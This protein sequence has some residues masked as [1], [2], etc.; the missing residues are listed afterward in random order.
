MRQQEGRDTSDANNSLT[1]DDKD[2][3]STDVK[4]RRMGLAVQII[5]GLVLGLIC[6]I[7]FGEKVAWLKIAGGI[8][9]QLLQIPVIPYMSLALIT[10]IGRMSLEQVKANAKMGGGV[11]L[12][13]S[14]LILIVVLLMPLSFPDWPSAS[15]FST[16]QIEEPPAIDYLNLFIPAN[17]FNAYATAAIPAIVLFS[18]L[19]GIAIIS[20]PNKNAL[21]EPLGVLHTAMMKITKIIAKLAPIGVFAL[22]AGFAGTFEV[23]ELMRLQVYIVVYVLLTLMLSIVIIPGIITVFTPL[24]YREILVELR[25]PLITAF[26]TSSSLITLPLL[27]DSC[28]N[29]VIRHKRL[30]VD[31]KTADASID[32]L[33]PTFFTFPNPSTMLAISFILYAGWHLG[34]PISETSYPTLLLA[35]VPSLFGGIFVAVPF[36]LKLSQLPSDL[37]QL[38]ILISVFIARFGVLLSSMHYA[39]IGIIGT[40]AGTGEL[41]FRWLRLIRV[42]ATGSVLTVPILLGV[43]A[44]YTHVVV[45]PYTKNDLLKSLDFSTPP[46]PSQVFTKVPE[47]LVNLYENP[48]GLDAIIQRGV[49]RVCYQPGEYPSAFLNAADPPQLVGFD[50]EMAHR[51]ADDLDL[52]L[53][54]L[55]ALSES[56]AKDFLDRSVCDIY[57]RK[58]AVTLDRSR[59]FGMSNPVRTASLGIIVKDHRRDEFLNWD[60]IQKMGKSFHIGVEDTPG[61]MAYLR[62]LLKDA[63]IMPL[64]SMEQEIELL[65]SASFDIDAIADV[66]EEGAAQTLLYPSFNLVVPRPTISLPVSYAVARGNNDLLTSFNSW[67]MVKQSEGTVDKLYR[68]WAL[69]E[70]ATVKKEPRWSIIRNVLG[71]VE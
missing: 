27:M 43:W 70:A 71:W 12:L 33:I 21:L 7:F 60:D 36:L 38:F 68:H 6:G 14:V 63:T 67:L 58:R 62:T 25:T 59:K 31:P 53:E 2:D 41:R 1:N 34:S 19:I 29:L 52:P 16:S 15:F 40:L 65:A 3:Q 22:I 49:L 20:L 56:D 39:A 9:I 5:I 57:M 55:P 44:F 18:I 37:F 51:F 50:I 66:A 46:Q 30:T 42:V 10:G 13:N 28:K 4:P 32:M 35:G 24:T 61:N 11:F 54:F 64:K 23:E 8:F 26:A 47:N 17:P 48:A 69:G 45:V